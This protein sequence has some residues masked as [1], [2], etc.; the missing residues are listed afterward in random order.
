M[1]PKFKTRLFATLLFVALLGALR[2]ATPTTLE[3]TLSL[4]GENGLEAT[5]V[6]SQEELEFLVGKLSAHERRFNSLAYLSQREMAETEG[7]IGPA[8]AIV[9][10]ISGAAGYIGSSIGS[11][12]GSISGLAGATVTGAI[13]GFLM[14]P[15]GSIAA[16]SMLFGQLGFYGGFAGGLAERMC[17]SCH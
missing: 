9:G 10:A 14:G 13:G 1:N 12:D 16:N 17:S 6:L 3:D 2:S 15:S 4:H 8:G 11:G 5:Q 7:K